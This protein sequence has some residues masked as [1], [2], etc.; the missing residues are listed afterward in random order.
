MKRANIIVIAIIVEA[1][2]LTMTAHASSEILVGPGKSPISRKLIKA[3]SALSTE[4]YTKL[5][6][7]MVLTK[8]RKYVGI[9]NKQAIAKSIELI[10]ISDQNPFAE[11][12]MDRQVWLIS[13]TPLEVERQDNTTSASVELNVVIDANSLRLLEVFTKAND[14]WVL[15]QIAQRDPEQEAEEDGWSVSPL[16]SGELE[17]SAIEALSTLWTFENIDPQKAGQIILRPRIVGCALP[18]IEVEGEL[19]PVRKPAPVWIVHVLG[20]LTWKRNRNDVVQYMSGLIMLIDDKTKN[21]V[22]GVYLP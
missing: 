21:V 7:E 20:T 13:F 14:T 4:T 16:K 5:D 9:T 10:G 1:F 11:D 22:R 18:A 8:A 12:F 19:I 15:P 2:I 3:K 6:T 17:F